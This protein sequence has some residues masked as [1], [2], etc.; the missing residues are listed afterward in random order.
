ME[1][2]LVTPEIEAFLHFG[3]V[4]RVPADLGSRPW[5]STRAERLPEDEAACVT[6]GVESLCALFVDVP[7]GL[8]LVPLSGGLDSRVIL[9]ML[10]AAGHARRVLAVTFGTPGTLDYELG[11]QVARHA[12]VHH[13]AIDLTREPLELEEVR[14]AIPPGQR[15]VH[16]L[17]AHFNALV[18]RRFGAGATVWSGI[19]ANTLNGS[20]V[21]DER[22]SWDE[23][24]RLYARDH[25]CVRSTCLTRPG[26]DPLAWLPATPFAASERLTPHELLHVAFHYPCRFDPVLLAPGYAY[27]TPFRDPRWVDFALALPREFRRGERLFRAVIRAALPDLAALPTKSRAGVGLDAPA[28]QAWLAAQRARA[29]RRVRRRFPGLVRTPRPDTNYLDQELELRRASPLRAL[30]QTCLVRLRARGVVP[31]LDLDALERRHAEARADHSD[32]LVQLALLE[33]NLQAQERDLQ[34]EER[35]QRV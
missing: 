22:A 19:M 30:V 34:A 35:A 28:W 14:A 31:W 21:G 15:W 24:R 18:P 13:E 32:A 4:P 11:A 1:A 17:E 12:G 16:A 5:L 26:F 2:R 3:F 23:A 25:R 7:D 33:L 8:Q 20:R 6:R 29:A 10:V 27:R 9:G